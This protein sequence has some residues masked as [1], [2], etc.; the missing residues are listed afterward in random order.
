[1]PAHWVG[2]RDLTSIERQHLFR[3]EP[4]QVASNDFPGRPNR[5]GKFLVAHRE[6]QRPLGMLG[7]AHESAVAVEQGAAG[8]NIAPG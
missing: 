1:M 5:F 2:Q 3:L 4:R 7:F 6:H 8:E